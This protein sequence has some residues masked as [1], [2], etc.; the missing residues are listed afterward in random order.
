MSATH[1]Y[2][3]I[4]MY[5]TYIYIYIHM[6][7]NIYIYIYIYYTYSYIYIHT[8]SMQYMWK[9][10]VGIMS[11]WIL[12]V[13]CACSLIHILISILQLMVSHRGSPKP[14]P[15]KS[16]WSNSKSHE[17]L[18][19]SPWNHHWPH[20]EISKNHPEITIDLT[21]KSLNH[22]EITIKSPPSRWTTPSCVALP[23]T[24]PCSAPPCSGPRRRRFDAPSA[25]PRSGAGR[26][27]W[28]DAGI[29]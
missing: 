8:R 11:L 17:I 2:I 6:Y 15:W 5:Y 27:P 4:F 23:S 25:W 18:F 26:R 14:F 3:Y 10:Q 16:P 20:H 1:I 21:K 9:Q 28:S 7:I 22:P 19:K 24:A 29:S 12:H 13:I